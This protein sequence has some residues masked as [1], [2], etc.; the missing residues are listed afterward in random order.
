[1]NK[2][3]ITFVFIGLVV[4]ALLTPFMVFKDLLFPFVTSK[5]FYLR[6]LVELA[7]PFYLYLFLR[8]PQYRP[9]YKNPLT[10]SIFGFFL[11]NLIAGIFGVNPLRS[12]WGNFE[13]MGGVFYLGHLCLLYFYVL[14]IGQMNSRYLR[15]FLQFLVGIGVTL[16]LDGVMVQLTRNHFLLNDPSYPRVSGTFGNPIF[17]ASFLVIPMFLSAFFAVSAETLWKK[18]M[19]WAFVLLQLWVILLS[20]TRGCVVGLGIG[21]FVAAVL[22]VVLN[23]SGKV[24]LWG[25]SVVLAFGVIV[26]LLF[27]FHADLPQGGMLHRVFNLRDSN[28]EARLIQW[29]VALKGYKDHLL[30]GVGPEDYYFIANKYYNPAIHQYDPSWFDKPHNYLIEVLVE[31]GIFGFLAYAGLQ[32][33]S[34]WALWAAFRKQILI[35][36]E[37]CLLVCGL[38]VYQVQ[39]LFVFDTVGASMAFFIYIG[40]M[41]YLWHEANK[42]DAKNKSAGLDPL[43]VN[44]AFGLSAAVILYIVYLGNITG[45]YVAKDINY[46]YAYASVD[47]QIA[48]NYFVDAQNSPF[49]FDPVQFSSKYADSAVNLSISP[50]KGTSEEFIKQ[51]LQDAIT[52]QQDTINHVPNDPTAWQELANL[53]LASSTFNKTALDPR[54]L[55]A[56]QTAMNL[57]PRRPEPEMVMARLDFAENNTAGAEALYEKIISDIPQNSQAKLMLAVVYYY[58]G[59][60]DKGLQLA[61]GVLDSGYTPPQTSLFSWMGTMY[62][63]QNNF[64]AAAKVYEL[65]AKI[66]P[67]DLQNQWLLAQDYAKLGQK[68]RAIAIVQSLISADPT[69]A[70]HF[71]EFINSLK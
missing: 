1:M 32:I 14:M 63:K 49:D 53:Y 17:I 59:Q 25:G 35:L 31:S 46:G 19:Y 36:P 42:K 47:P 48:K 3:F 2:K 34:L 60:Q 45:I 24:R 54:A 6:I 12:I 27:T 10:I 4:L 13:R 43:F 55:Q 29:G 38:I 70:S 62:D 21:I 37:F 30:L 71:Q 61:Q 15:L 8:Y 28:T 40:L 11:F 66:D 56:A 9:S 26:A 50:P 67:S 68:D 65:V 41:G 7:L 22:Y 64:T 57:A 33:F 18:I 16:S 52:V 5:A 39:N 69:D 23:P 20:Q 44:V 51:N 58:Y